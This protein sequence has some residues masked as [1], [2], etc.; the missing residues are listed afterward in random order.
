MNK[1]ANFDKLPE[2]K[3]L[4]IINAG[5][6]CFG[7]NEYRKAS[8]ADMAAEAGISKAAIFHYFGSKKNFYFYLYNYVS[9]ELL[10][11]MPEG[12]EDFFESVLAFLRARARLGGKHPG[13]YEFLRLQLEKGDADKIK[14]F[15]KIKCQKDELG[16]SKVFDN[17]NWN[18]FLDCYDR[19]TA[20]NLV[21]WVGVG[22]LTHFAETHS[23]EEVYSE[24]E[25]YLAILKKAMY[26]PEY[27]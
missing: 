23:E 5:V 12:G 26:K 7:C 25:R 10:A 18:K 3:R 21:T 1:T 16:A 11:E 17:V 9:D 2:E 15:G 24:I 27:L 22:C 6:K 19:D 20:Q 14:G 8:A 13:I 4:A